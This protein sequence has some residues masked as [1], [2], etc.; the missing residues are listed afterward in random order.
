VRPVGNRSLPSMLTS[1]SG[2]ISASP[3]PEGPSGAKRIAGPHTSSRLK[4]KDRTGTQMTTRTNRT[5]LE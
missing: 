3:H 2:S 4:R 1:M 5:T